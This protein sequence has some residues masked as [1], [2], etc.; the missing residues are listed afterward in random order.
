MRGLTV[1][2]PAS[3]T[4]LWVTARLVL[5]LLT[6]GVPASNTRQSIA[7]STFLSD[8]VRLGQEVEHLPIGAHLVSPRRF[9]MHHGIY[10]GRGEVAHYSGFSSSLKAGPVE[11]TDLTDFASN[12]PVW[13][14]RERGRFSNEEIVKRARSRVG[15]N[16]YKL[17]SNNC[18]HFCSWCISGKSYSA[19][20]NAYV[21]CPRFMLCLISALE[22]RFI[23]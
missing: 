2:A 15:E 21:H 11:I 6:Q 20:I 14:M 18:E 16:R 13:L 7:A 5:A 10:L 4:T 23:A 3:I 1:K 8:F 9:Y 12:K 22:S 17:L 19:Q